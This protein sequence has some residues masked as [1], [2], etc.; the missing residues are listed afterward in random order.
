MCPPDRAAVAA[1]L[2]GRAFVKLCDTDDALLVSDAPK[3]MDGQALAG[4]LTRLAQAGYTAQ[5]TPRGLLA[6]DWTESRWQELFEQNITAGEP[7]LPQ[8]EALHA[9]YALATLLLLHPAPPAQQ[10]KL[11]L[12]NL[13]KA[14]CRKGGL[15]AA[16][17]PMLAACA[18]RLRMHQALPTAAASL[19]V[20]VL[21]TEGEANG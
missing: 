7:A 20:A 13:L 17:P 8:N 11:L 4:A 15:A 18:Q 3:R 6:I 1:I 9:C 21:H 5:T 2:G 10:P 12:R 16:A 14:A 19:L